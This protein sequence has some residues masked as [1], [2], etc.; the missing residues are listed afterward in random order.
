MQEMADLNTPEILG[1]HTPWN[2]FLDHPV[3]S[4]IHLKFICSASILM[5]IFMAH[6]EQSSVQ[7]AVNVILWLVKNILL[8]NEGCDWSVVTSLKLSLVEIDH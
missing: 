7:G 3:E 6:V 5:W 4:F 1:K 8:Q 2:Y